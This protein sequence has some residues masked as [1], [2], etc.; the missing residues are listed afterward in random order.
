MASMIA[1]RSE[2]GA[3]G[4]LSARFNSTVTSFARGWSLRISG[5]RSSLPKPRAATSATAGEGSRN[6]YLYWAMRRALEEGVPP[7]FAADY[8]RPA[9]IKAGLT[10]HET[11]LTL[12]SAYDAAGQ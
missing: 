3:P 8:L 1:A 11:K 4:R 10:D 12:R 9:A 5:A 2:A 6:N 7:K